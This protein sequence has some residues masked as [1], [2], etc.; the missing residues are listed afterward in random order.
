MAKIKL[1]IVSEEAEKTLCVY[2]YT[3]VEDETIKYVG[4]VRKG[5]LSRR[6]HEHEISDDWCKGR[7]WYVEYFECDTQSE[8]EAFEAHLISLYHTDRFFNIKKAGWG[9]NKYLPDVEKW[10]KPALLPKYEDYETMRAVIKFR[11][12]IREHRMVEAKALLE[13]I[14]IDYDKDDGDGKNGTTQNRN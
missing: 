5:M 8:V 10:W 6:I 2:R 7:N 13:L 14:D 9:I 1:G 12:L 11:K 3:D 4:I